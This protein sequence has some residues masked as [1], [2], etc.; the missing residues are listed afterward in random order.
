[1]I[2]IISIVTIAVV[3]VL[4]FMFNPTAKRIR[5]INALIDKDRSVCDVITSL[6]DWAVIPVDTGG[7]KIVL[8]SSLIIK[9]LYI[10]YKGERPTNA[11]IKYLHW[12]LTREDSVVT[13]AHRVN[14]PVEAYMAGV[15]NSFEDFLRSKIK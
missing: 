7:L 3:V 9:E 6:E 15:A 5:E 12:E 4:W 13:K 10:T 14:M 1:M 2:Y 8:P 11:D